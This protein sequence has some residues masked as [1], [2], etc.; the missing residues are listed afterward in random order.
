MIS[1]GI[2]RSA[3]VYVS[4]WFCLDAIA[5]KRRWAL[6]ESYWCEG[7]GGRLLQ[8]AGGTCCSNGDGLPLTAS[9]K[10]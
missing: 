6:R 8:P 4:F 2:P 10:P 5:E 1:M 7:G 3:G 9:D